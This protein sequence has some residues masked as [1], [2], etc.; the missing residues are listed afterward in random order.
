MIA[1]ADVVAYDNPIGGRLNAY[2]AL[3]TYV[4]VTPRGDGAAVALG[5]V[6]PNPLRARAAT[7]GASVSFHLPRA[8]EVAL[9]V[10]DVRGRRIATIAR[11]SYEAGTHRASW[12]GRDA[13]GRAVPAGLYFVSGTLAGATK[14][15]RVTVLP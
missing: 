5:P 2:N 8:G 3:L 13:A 11:G 9:S 14:S 15:A 1:T 10:L 7:A 4:D 6:V 12:D